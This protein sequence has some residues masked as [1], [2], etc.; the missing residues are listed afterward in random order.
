LG[1]ISAFAGMTDECGGVTER[2][3]G[4]DCTPSIGAVNPTLTSVATALRVADRIEA[5]LAGGP[6]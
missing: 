3:Y 1:L 6:L 2:G 4:A 5:R